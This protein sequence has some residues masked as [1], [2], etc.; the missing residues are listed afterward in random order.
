MI[1]IYGCFY[2]NRFNDAYAI[3]VKFD[4]LHFFSILSTFNWLS[5]IRYALHG[6]FDAILHQEIW[7]LQEV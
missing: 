7:V 2:F 1:F 5:P 4:Y 3:S 6:G